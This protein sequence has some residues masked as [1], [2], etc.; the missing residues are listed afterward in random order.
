MAEMAPTELR[1][2]VL[3]EQQEQQLPLELLVAEELE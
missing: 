1:L 2:G 3:Q